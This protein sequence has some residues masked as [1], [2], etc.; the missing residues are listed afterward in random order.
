MMLSPLQLPPVHHN[1]SYD[2]YARDAE[3]N[4]MWKEFGRIS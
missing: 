1:P 2:G 3:E 4:R